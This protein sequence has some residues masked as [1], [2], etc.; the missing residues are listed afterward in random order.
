MCIILSN[1]VV[2]QRTSS[3]VVEKEQCPKQ[4][5]NTFG[6]VETQRTVKNRERVFHVTEGSLDVFSLT[7]N[8]S[9]KQTIRCIVQPTV[10]DWKHQSFVLAISAIGDHII[11]GLDDVV[12]FNIFQCILGVFEQ[13]LFCQRLHE[14]LIRI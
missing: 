10:F 4:V 14:M 2:L 12:T 1:F 8:L 5:T 13:W 3:S 9:R 6:V 7:L 11:T